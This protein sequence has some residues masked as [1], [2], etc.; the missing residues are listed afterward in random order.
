L[1]S[2]ADIFKDNP[3]SE[4]LVSQLNQQV[5]QWKADGI[6]VVGFRMPSSPDMVE[7]ENQVS[8]FDELE[9]K[10]NFV[11]AGGIWLDFSLNDYHSY[12]GSHLVAES[13]LQ[14]SRD[15]AEKLKEILP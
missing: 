6:I 11:K 9:I 2:Y 15:L 4:Q 8:G 13:A 5:V 1:Q 3:V 12:D 7:L 14:F 10:E